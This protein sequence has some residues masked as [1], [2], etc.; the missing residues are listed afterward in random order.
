[1]KKLINISPEYPRIPHLDKSISKMT[2]DDILSDGVQYPIDCYVQEK[3]DGSNMGVSWQNNA[4]VLRNRKHILR[5]GY[6]KIRTPSKEQFKS[7]W[8]WVNDHKN[9]I[10]SISDIWMSQLTV[11]GEWMNFAHSI[12][13]DKLP[14][15]F[16]A[17]DIFSVEDDKYL[18]PDIVGNLLDK[19]SI[20][21]IKSEKIVFNSPEEIVR[22]SE[23]SSIYRDGM[24]EGIVIKT[25][26]G[27]FL[28][29]SYKIVNKHFVRRDDFN[30]SNPIKNKFK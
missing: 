8:N 23:E 9:D 16:I 4:A 3:I 19:T 29:E 7:A 20:F 27:S 30:T 21:Y 1:M 26:D 6:S 2:H 5:K 14:D 13:Y 10:K 25:S 11:Y 28:K 12:Y 15:I 18:S 22:K 17:Y 24:V